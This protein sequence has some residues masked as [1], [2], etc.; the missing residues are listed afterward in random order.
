MEEAGNPSGLKTLCAYGGVPKPPQVWDPC[1]PC[2]VAHLYWLMH[3]T[4]LSPA[5]C[6]YALQLTVHMCKAYSVAYSVG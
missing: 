3:P 2:Q 1:Q 6:R 4:H 5:C